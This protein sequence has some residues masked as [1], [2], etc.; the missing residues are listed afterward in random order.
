MRKTHSQIEI[1][2]TYLNE[3]FLYHFYCPEEILLNE[4]EKRKY[5]SSKS[6]SKDIEEL[7]IQL[8]IFES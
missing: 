1:A 4:D 5:L 8:S 3:V 2:G 7:I 6:I